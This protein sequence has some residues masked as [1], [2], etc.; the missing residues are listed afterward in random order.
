MIRPINSN[1]S[2]PDETSMGVNWAHVKV[3]DTSKIVEILK[4]D[5]SALT[6][7][8][9]LLL[10]VGAAGIMAG[11]SEKAISMNNTVLIQLL[12]CFYT[13]STLFAAVSLIGGSYSYL[14]INKMGD[15]YEAAIEFRN[16]II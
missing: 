6:L 2:P 3:S 8:S 4:A 15:D 7:V 5:A 11:A 9:A 14:M 13:S 12:A 1:S 16:G 10:T